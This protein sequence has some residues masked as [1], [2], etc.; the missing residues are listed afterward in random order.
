MS[1]LKSHRA[2]PWAP[3]PSIAACAVK[4]EK[5][6]FCP[7]RSESCISDEVHLSSTIWRRSALRAYLWLACRVVWDR[8]QSLRKKATHLKRNVGCI[9][10]C[11]IRLSHRKSTANTSLIRQDIK[12][13]HITAWTTTYIHERAQPFIFLGLSSIVV[14]N[15][16]VAGIRRVAV[17]DF[18]SERRL[19]ERNQFLNVTASYESW[20]ISTCAFFVWL[21]KKMQHDAT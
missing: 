21:W 14:Q 6:L 5:R 12:W 17:E 16:H 3:E 19:R 20:R 4:D 8:L 7:W 9:T 15:F 11:N 1:A 2:Y 18:W 13:K 10:G